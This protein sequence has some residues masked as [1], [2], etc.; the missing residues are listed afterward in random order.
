[1][2]EKLKHI[3][4]QFVLKFLTESQRQMLNLQPEYA[5]LV[6]PGHEAT[7]ENK[8]ERPKSIFDGLADMVNKNGDE[9]SKS[10]Q[11]NETDVSEDLE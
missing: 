10:R 2:H 6:L 8:D 9:E 3:Y 11:R 5:P 1:M 4:N 7:A